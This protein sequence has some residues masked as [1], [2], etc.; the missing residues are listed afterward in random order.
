MLSG[1]MPLSFGIV[2]PAGRQNVAALIKRVLEDER[3]PEMARDL[4]RLTVVTWHGA[5]S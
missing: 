3:L 2:G 4:F 1:A 5:N